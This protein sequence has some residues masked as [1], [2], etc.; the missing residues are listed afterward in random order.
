MSGEREVGSNGQRGSILTKWFVLMGLIFGLALFMGC[1]DVKVKVHRHLYKAQL[2]PSLTAVYN[3]KHI[4]VQSFINKDQKTRIWTYYSPDR[5]V[6]YETSV[7]LEYYLMDCFRDAFWMAGMSVVRDSPNP[8]IPDMLLV[9]DQWTD[10]ELKF[11][12]TVTQD[13]ALK[14]KNQYAVMM[15][16]VARG[17]KAGLEKNAYE[18]TNKAIV[19]VMADTKFQDCFK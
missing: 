8:K 3:G 12:V 2:P 6:A 10:M 4:D 7:P 11:T 5:K 13:N 9:I 1:A 15:P 16:S 17:D 14:Y 18:M 19:A